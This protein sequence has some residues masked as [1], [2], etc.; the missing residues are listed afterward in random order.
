MASSTASSVIA[1]TDSYPINFRSFTAVDEDDEIPGTASEHSF[2]DESENNIR[3]RSKEL[4]KLKWD[5][6]QFDVRRP[7]ERKNYERPYRDLPG[8]LADFE[9]LNVP[10]RKCTV[11]SAF[12][13]RT[14]IEEVFHKRNTKS[15]CPPERSR[16]LEHCVEDVI[17][18]DNV[19]STAA[20]VAEQVDD[21]E[22]VTEGRIV[23][24]E[25]CKTFFRARRALL[26]SEL[27]QEYFNGEPAPERAHECG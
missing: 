14:P 5:K 22:Q 21:V 2:A 13:R 16:A 4:P 15:V 27:F 24:K 6:E 3:S 10:V 25:C 7:Y 12:A 8:H 17:L 18:A 20:S 9:G 19:S 23:S 26:R 11:P 1:S